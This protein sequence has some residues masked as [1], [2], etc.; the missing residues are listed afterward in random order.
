M[1]I[2][3]PFLEV[4]IPSGTSSINLLNPTIQIAPITLAITLSRLQLGLSA[5]N[6]LILQVIQHLS[7]A[8]GKTSFLKASSQQ[9]HPKWLTLEK[10]KQTKN[11]QT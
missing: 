8:V 7:L 3:K 2:G 5:D 1:D 6:P 10:A 4:K 11:T 9:I